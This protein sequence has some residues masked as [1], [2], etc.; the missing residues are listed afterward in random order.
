M[1]NCWGIPSGPRDFAGSSAYS[2]SHSSWPFMSYIR[3]ING[4]V[5]RRKQDENL[6]FIDLCTFGVHLYTTSISKSE[7]WALQKYLGNFQS[8]TLSCPFVSKVRGLS[9][10][11]VG[12][13]VCTIMEYGVSETPILKEQFDSS[14]RCCNLTWIRHLTFWH[15]S[16]QII[17]T[18][19]K[20]ISRPWT[21]WTLSTSA[22]QSGCTFPSFTY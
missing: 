8:V 3:D 10:G 19:E 18:K 16:G 12:Q 17:I 5:V 1:P 20:F 7:K 13:S 15:L 4:I 22:I 6:I 11:G 9:I 14:G 2:L 21:I